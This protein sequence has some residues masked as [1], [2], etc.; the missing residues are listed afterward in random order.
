[1]AVSFQRTFLFACKTRI[2][3]S[4][5]ETFDTISDVDSSNRLDMLRLVSE[6]SNKEDLGQLRA[7]EKESEVERRK[8]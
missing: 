1:M 2:F 7:D 4:Y 5:F 6:C 8:L 3:C